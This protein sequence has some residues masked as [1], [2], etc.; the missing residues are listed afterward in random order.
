M[1]QLPG[2]SGQIENFVRARK[3]IQDSTREKQPNRLQ[4][5]ILYG[6]MTL[7]PDV[8]RESNYFGDPIRTLVVN[9]LITLQVRMNDRLDFENAPNSDRF[10]SIVLETR[11]GERAVREEIGQNID[12]LTPP[13][14]SAE[15][16]RIIDNAT[17]EVEF[18]EAYI[19]ERRG[20]LSFLDIVRYR[21]LVN[22][23]SCCAVIAT[24]LGP[25]YFSDRLG[26]IDSESISW[27]AVYTKYQWL[28]DG[29]PLDLVE[30]TLMVIHNIVMASQVDDDWYGRYIDPILGVSS[31][32]TAA[33][34]ETRGGSDPEINMLLQKMKR[35][36]IRHAR[37]LG[38]G[39]IPT[40]AVNTVQKTVQK[41]LAAVTRIGR[42]TQVK[43]ICH[44]ISP[45]L[46]L[47]EHLYAQDKI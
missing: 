13:E 44:R 2:E 16:R 24:M 10:E 18:V 6:L 19:A 3:E 36:Y 29:K 23:I 9:N 43:L 1:T 41:T 40:T 38:I 17:R 33:A 11:E 47:R 22:A 28:F 46:G 14:R 8:V 12:L 21:N 37:N 42:K 4:R 27:Q 5:G 45:R 32:Y 34:I 20:S 31:L 15:T 7:I 26:S 25:V 35:S 39:Y 30:R